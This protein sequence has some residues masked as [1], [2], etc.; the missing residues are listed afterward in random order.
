MLEISDYKLWTGSTAPSSDEQWERIVNVA[1]SRLASFLCLSTLPTDGDGNLADDLQMLLANFI[2]ATLKVQGDNEEVTSKRVRNFTI[3]FNTDDAANAFASIAK[4]YGDIID[5]YS[6]CGSG[7]IVE[8]SVGR[9][10][11]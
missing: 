10:C 6:D 9:C 3:T 5:L 4:R 7:I 8:R 1:A 2:A 11:R